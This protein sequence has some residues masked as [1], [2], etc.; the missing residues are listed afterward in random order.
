[1]QRFS[2]LSDTDSNVD[3]K[4][5]E[6]QALRRSIQQGRSEPMSGREQTMFLRQIERRIHGTLEK[7]E[8]YERN[9][10]SMKTEQ[11]SEADPMVF[12]NL[13]EALAFNKKNIDSL[14]SDSEERCE[15]QVQIL[16]QTFEHL[17]EQSERIVKKLRQERSNLRNA[18]DQESKGEG[19]DKDK[20]LTSEQVLAQAEEF[21]IALKAD[22]EKSAQDIQRFEHTLE[23]FHSVIKDM[24]DANGMNSTY[25]LRLQ[26]K[27]TE[28]EKEIG[29]MRKENK[30]LQ[31]KVTER[32]ELVRM[33]NTK[34]TS[35]KAEIDQLKSKIEREKKVRFEKENDLSKS[36]E[37]LDLQKN[38]IK[39]LEVKL[40]EMEKKVANNT[41][42][43]RC[44]NDLANVSE[45]LEEREKQL[46]EAKTNIAS[47]VA[48]KESHLKMI[49]RL[50]TKVSENGTKLKELEEQITAS[51]SKQNELQEKIVEL[52]ERHKVDIKV[53]DDLNRV[54]DA[55][56]EKYESLQKERELLSESLEKGAP[57][58][59]LL[60]KQNAQLR[61][62]NMQLTDSYKKYLD[63]NAKLKENAKENEAKMTEQLR[64]IKKLEQE[65]FKLIEDYEREV[66]K[67]QSESAKV[68]TKVDTKIEYKTR[69]VDTSEQH[70]QTIALPTGGSLNQVLV[71]KEQVTG[72][73]GIM[74]ASRAKFLDQIQTLQKERDSLIGKVDTFEEQI[75]KLQEQIESD[76]GKS[77]SGGN[78][79]RE[80][81]HKFRRLSQV[82]LDMR[83]S[84]QTAVQET[85]EVE[86][87]KRI[88]QSLAAKLKAALAT[89]ENLRQSHKFN[90]KKK[91]SRRKSE[92]AKSPGAN[93]GKSQYTTKTNGMVKKSSHERLR[94][95][96]IKN[97]SPGRRSPGVGIVTSSSKKTLHVPV[98]RAHTIDGNLVDSQELRREMDAEMEKEES[99]EKEQ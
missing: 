86:K 75:V 85:V 77:E 61:K 71:L 88:V 18:Y 92:K 44:Q 1:M 23:D 80:S 52:D 21:E 63:E 57:E 97:V 34:I 27:N 20:A 43:I 81:L 84:T 26:R 48:V 38:E 6:Y 78:L 12:M 94:S 49:A 9:G 41:E 58:A 50:E 65:K 16:E 2:R 13:E 54:H 93:D 96:M 68:I 46:E 33:K 62:E 83:A 60:Q 55:L 24:E 4:I 15:N 25:R 22:Q 11:S 69:Q 99:S 29:R 98:P 72:L 95:K 67:A 7:Y 3:Q 51:D 31:M 42:L 59:T 30:G 90:N 53:M 14:V 76:F 17:K 82:V 70:T 89:N 73:R 40:K 87:L 64:K 10:I 8:S 37:R 91:R 56:R 36:K 28:L 47:L 5:L 66:L 45:Q 19:S 74:E 32:E 35:F 79:S 39:L